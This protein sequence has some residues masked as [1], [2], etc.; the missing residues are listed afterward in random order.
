M[1]FANDDADVAVVIGSGAGGAVVANELCQRGRKVVLLEAGARI[2]R[3][4]FRNDELFAFQQLTWFGPR[5][6]SGNWP[7]AATSPGFPAYT[8]KAVGGTTNHWGALAFRMQPHE[9]RAAGTYGAIAGAA[10]ADW[11]I[12]HDELSHY[13]S[14]AESRMGVTGTHGIPLLPVTN[15]YKVLHYGAHR[16]GYR[17]VANDRHAINSR[18]RDGRAACIQLGFCGQ[19]CKSGA[20]WSTLET[21]IPAA[22]ATGRL[23]LRTGATALQLET[24][25][26]GRVSAVVYADSAGARLRQRAT[27]VAL[28]A[29]AIE[30]PRLLLNSQ[31]GR[32]PAGLANGS[33]L[34]GRHY[35]KHVNGSAWGL[36]DKPVN[37][38]RG[39]A[40]GGTVYD[41]SRL[42]VA[43]GFTGGYLLQAAQVGVPF[44]AAV[45]RPDG[46]GESFTRYIDAYDHLAGIWLNGEDLPRSDNRVT[47]DPSLRDAHGMPAAHVHVDEHPN[48][49]AMREHFHRQSAALLEAA[50]ARSVLRGAPVPASHN[51]GTC[52]MA[53]RSDDGVT[54]AYGQAHEVPNLYISDGSLF[55]TSSAQ[56]P[57][58]TIVALAL[59]QAEYISRQS[60]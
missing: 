1:R 51:L 58:L 21:E 28:A 42:D 41:E 6:I 49:V 22:E 53:V 38:N 48:D 30:T 31:S 5:S 60:V 17:Q 29:N 40:M 24:D 9:L 8:G 2:E 19:G 37:M 55:P 4:A 52:R 14:L 32:H 34:V 39:V 27:V 20:K 25:A 26:T 57:T 7:V 11:P 35:M 16:I 50:G 3:D 45:I 44:L 56:N 10:L 23:D 54:N 33:G 18:P 36:F 59:R 43:R 47:L 12:R 13:W 46:W 15:N